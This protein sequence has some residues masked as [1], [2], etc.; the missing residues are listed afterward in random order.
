MGTFEDDSE[1]LPALDR[2]LRAAAADPTKRGAF[3]RL[4]LES[5]IYVPATA[6]AIG[7][8]A[9][10]GRVEFRKGDRIVI[11]NVTLPDGHVALLFYSSEQM[12][13]SCLGEGVPALAFGCRTFF[14]LASGSVLLMNHGS[15]WI[16]RFD[17]AEV[18]SLLEHGWAGSPID[19]EHDQRAQL[20]P[21]DSEP[22]AMLAAMTT[23]LTLHSGVTAAYI[24]L[25]RYPAIGDDVFFIVGLDG[26]S[27]A[28]AAIP[29]LGPVAAALAPGRTTHFMVVRRGD[30]DIADWLIANGLRFFSRS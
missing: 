9:A 20:R 25:L 5:D 22:T 30:G 10:S 6:A 13:A 18:A 27:R 2:A 8:P 4:L 23:V 26:D 1:G 21:V 12:L 11:R 24:A 16:K 3:T 28:D 14:E 7:A 15:R 29:D 19:T 17:P